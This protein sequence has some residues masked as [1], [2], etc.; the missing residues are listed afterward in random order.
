[1]EKI[2]ISAA[3]LVII[4]LDDKYLLA[5]NKTRSKAGIKVFTPLGGNLKFN[6]SAKLF[7]VSLGAEFE[8][9]NGLRL[10]MPKKN[11][12]KFEQWF[13]KKVQREITPYREL[14][15]E[16]VDEIK[17]FDKLPRHAVKFKFIQTKK[18]RRITDRPGQKGKLTQRYFEIFEVKLI[19][20][21]EK[22]L[23]RKISKTNKLELITKKEIISKKSK[24]KI[25][26]GTNCRAL[27]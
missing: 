9:N 3:T 19:P 16:L 18:E 27:I 6:K 11:L 12:S 4:K 8:Q 22:I 5:L 2:R 26:I 13:K 20:K 15:E 17:V 23:R 21:Y 24:S 14:K 25:R 10:S 7:L 1:M